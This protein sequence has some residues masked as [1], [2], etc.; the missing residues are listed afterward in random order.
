M[1]KE[2]S[3]PTCTVLDPPPETFRFSGDPHTAFHYSICSLG[4]WSPPNR[5]Q[6]PEG[7]KGQVAAGGCAAR[8]ASRP[9]VARG[10]SGHLCGVTKSVSPQGWEARQALTG[11]R[12]VWEL[13]DCFSFC[14]LPTHLPS[15]KKK[16]PAEPNIGCAQA[17]QKG[18]L[19]MTQVN[20]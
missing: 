4:Y 1:Q 14:S 15:L 12:S 20:T 13:T 18:E 17:Q 6:L 7:V 10:G 3:S 9:S 19:I 11:A 2:E 8:L 16:K 5:P